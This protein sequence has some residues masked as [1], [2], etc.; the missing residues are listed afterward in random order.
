VHSDVH[1]GNVLTAD[2]IYFIDWEYAQVGDPLIDLAC[3]MAYYPRAVP[4]GALLL[5]ASGLDEAGVTPE[6][7]TELTRVF[8]LLT[9]LWYRARRLARNV[10]ATDLQLEATALR[11]LLT[12]APDA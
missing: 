2:R 6:M 10:P 1:H 7:L 11:R 9:Y 8:N 4:H 3:I 5:Q 12:L